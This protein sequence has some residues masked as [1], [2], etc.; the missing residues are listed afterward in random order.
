ME[1]GKRDIVGYGVK[2]YKLLMRWI[3]DFEGK[4]ILIREVNN[5]L[6]DS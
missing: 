1:K 6:I 5:K 2:N 4:I 3:L